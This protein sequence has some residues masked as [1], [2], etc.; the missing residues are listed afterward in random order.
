MILIVKLKKLLSFFINKFQLPFS[1]LFVF[2]PQCSTV[3]ALDYITK[4]NR[5]IDLGLTVLIN[6]KVIWQFSSHGKL[7]PGET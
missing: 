6:C 3:F 5:L 2:L 1:P 4:F 7:K